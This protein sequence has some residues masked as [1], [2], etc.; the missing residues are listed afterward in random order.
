MKR[1]VYVAMM[2]MILA[3]CHDEPR[4]ASKLTFTSEEGQLV[5]SHN[6]F[7]LEMLRIVSEDEEEEGKNVFLSPLSASMVVAMTANGAEGRTLDQLMDALCPDETYA[8][9]D[10]NLFYQQLIK[11]L[12]KLD[13]T[14]K[15]ELANAIWLAN[16]YPVNADFAQAVKQYYLGEVANIDLSNPANAKTI[17]DWASRHTHGCIKKVC[18]E[19]Y[20]NND[21]N[22]IVANALYFKGKWAESFKKTATKDDV[23]HA[24]NGQDITV[25][26]MQ[27][28]DKL[29]VSGTICLAGEEVTEVYDWEPEETRKEVTA[30]DVPV[31]MLTLYYKDK[32]FAMDIILPG[33]GVDV[34]DVLDEL[35]ADKVRQMDGHTFYY[36]VLVKMPRF[37]MQYHRNLTNDMRAMGITDLFDDKLCSLPGITDVRN[38]HLSYLLQ[39][40][41]LK[42]DEEGTEA[43][44]VSIGWGYDAMEDSSAP[45]I[46][47]RPFVVLI[48]ERQ[49]GLILFAGKISHPEE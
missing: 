42:V 45:F 11:K 16:A 33:E 44:A 32:Q 17:N 31:R 9:N 20:F 41:Y 27:Q 39:D 34:E 37:S 22:V 15:L 38:L 7:S 2:A 13:Y 35:T 36:N 23:F 49:T 47:N 26:M 4:S 1:I 48:R 18:D 8:L 43:A 19:T 6:D 28:E 21:L 5:N 3:G 30:E 10:L 25:K 29:R 40:T 14:T 12:P 24:A 46:V